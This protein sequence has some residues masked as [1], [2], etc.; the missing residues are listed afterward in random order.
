[1]MQKL[2]QEETL[3]VN[4]EFMYLLNNIFRK[5]RMRFLQ[6]GAKHFLLI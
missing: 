6:S 3:L 5:I 2:Y 1:M 4:H